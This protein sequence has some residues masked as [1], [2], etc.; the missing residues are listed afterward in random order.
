MITLTNDTINK[1]DINL[2]IEWLKTEPRLTKGEKTIE[3]EKKFAKMNGSKYS[4]F[5]NSGSSA[6]LLMLWTLIEMGLKNKKIVVP[7]LSWHTDVSHPIHLG[8]QP[9]LCDCNLSDLSVDL[10]HLEEIFISEQPSSLLLVSVLGLVPDMDK[11]KELCGKY[12]V[13]LIEDVCES[14][15]SEFNGIKLGNFGLMGCYSSYF[16][17]HF[18]TI[19][20]GLIV[21]NSD[22]IYEKLLMFRSHGWARDLSLE[23]QNQL[24]EEN[25]ISDFNNLYTFYESGFNLRNTDLGAFLGINQLDKII[26]FVEK[27]NTNYN[28]YKK[29]IKNNLLELTDY[30]NRFVSNFCFPV[31]VENRDEVINKLIKNGV[32][33]RP[34]IAGSMGRQPFWIKR[35]GLVELKNCDLIHEKGFYLPNHHGLVEEEIIKISKIINNE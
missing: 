20:G 21:T 29:H 4:V 24:K 18:S 22:E 19:E 30:S 17:H 5:V 1:E 10:N 25:N 7:S 26:N 16:S 11:I 33:V 23:K 3:F 27:R 15:F 13:L 31:V 2:L 34:L 35:Y 32:E 6:I 28:L 9:I 8:M 12:D 14:L